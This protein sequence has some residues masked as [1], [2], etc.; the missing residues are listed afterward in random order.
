MPEMTKITSVLSQLEQERSFLKS[1]LAQVG[2]ALSALN[3]RVSAGVVR[4]MSAAGRAR[5]AAAQRARWAKLK[6]KKPS[7]TGAVKKRKLS[8]AALARIRA[9]Q[10]ARWAKWRQQ[11]KAAL[12]QIAIFAI[13]VYSFGCLVKSPGLRSA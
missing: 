7:T 3:A 10:K 8:G 6:G 5:I 11:Q 13:T 4:T 2:N 1:Q 9:A 12:S